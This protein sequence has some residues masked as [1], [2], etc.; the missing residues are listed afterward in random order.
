MK[1]IT[2]FAIVSVL[3]FGLFSCDSEHKRTMFTETSDTEFS[4]MQEVSN[5]EFLPNETVTEFEI[6]VVRNGAENEATVDIEVVPGGDYGDLFTYSPSVTFPE[7]V[8]QTALVLTF[9]SDDLALGGTYVFRLSIPEDMQPTNNETRVTA[10]STTILRDYDWG[11]SNTGIYVDGV[12]NTWYNVSYPIPFYVTYEIADVGDGTT[13]FR[14][15]DPFKRPYETS[16]A[17]GYGVYNQYPYNFGEYLGERKMIIREFA[18]DDVQMDTFR[19]GY[20]LSGDGELETG[21]TNTLTGTTDYPVGSRTGD[22]I[23]F[24]PTALYIREPA[25]GAAAAGYETFLFLTLE[26]YAEWAGI[27]L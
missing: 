10:M 18:A 11:S 1:K 5:L 9:D 21:M 8:F 7:G 12:I 24:P 2:I 17:D 15:M 22:T 20:D 4:F 23:L 26:A 3:A 19:Y 13:N 6:F 27:D 16:V 14:L 25:Y